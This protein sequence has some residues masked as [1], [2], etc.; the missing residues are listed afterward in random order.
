MAIA[1]ERYFTVCHPFF[2]LS[3]NWSVKRYIIPIVVLSLAYNLP[4]L[5]ELEVVQVIGKQ[6]SFLSD[7]LH[8]EA[9]FVLLYI[10]QILPEFLQIFTLSTPPKWELTTSM[11]F[12]TLFGQTYL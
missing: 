12:T 10:F 1:I 3:H 11:S 9:N 2:K 4:K 6:F 8:K 7:T 5:W